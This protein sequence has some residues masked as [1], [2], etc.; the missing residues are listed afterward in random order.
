MGEEP[1]PEGCPPKIAINNVQQTMTPEQTGDGQ[2]NL[3]R[4]MRTFE[5]IMEDEKRNS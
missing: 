1:P 3:P 4:K 5:Q 2:E